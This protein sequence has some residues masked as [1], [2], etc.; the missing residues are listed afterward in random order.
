MFIATLN[1]KFLKGTPTEF[2][3]SYNWV[4]DRIDASEFADE[5][6]LERTLHKIG[7]R[8]L[9]GLKIVKA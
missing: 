6:I 2:G 9:A 8:H 7:F 3:T 4:V 1:G 5:Y